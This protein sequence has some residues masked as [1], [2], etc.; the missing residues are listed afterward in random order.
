MTPSEAEERAH[1]LLSRAEVACVTTIDQRG[2]PRTRAMFNLRN[3]TQFPGLTAFRA[4]HCG[5]LTTWFTTN[6]SS[7]KVPELRSNPA[8][9][10]YY[11]EPREFAGLMLGGDMDLVEDSATREA[12]WQPDWS[13]YYPGG[14]NDPDYAV[15]RLVPSE[16]RLY[17]K[18][19]TVE[20]M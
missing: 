14:P 8:V 16:A 3:A 1:D 11:C 18:L 13:L 10:V 20:L 5:G 19:Q 15:L 6:T 4:T 17:Y 12:M 7:A 2:R 9:S